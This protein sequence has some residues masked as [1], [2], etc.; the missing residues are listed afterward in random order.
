MKTEMK[1]EVCDVKK[2]EKFLI[3]LKLGISN[4]FLRIHSNLDINNFIASI[5]KMN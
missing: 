1:T 5:T 2:G 3:P 4:L